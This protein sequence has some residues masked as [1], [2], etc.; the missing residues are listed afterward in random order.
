M[1]DWL[2]LMDWALML[3]N[4]RYSKRGSMPTKLAEFFAAGVRP[5][6]HGCNE[7]VSRKIREAGAGVVLEGI[8]ESDLR[9]GARKV[10][11]TS[12]QPEETL[13]ARELTRAHFSLEAG[14]EKYAALLHKLY[15]QEH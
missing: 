15:S 2:K 14:V 13:R 10:A 7:E 12:L 4:T 3:L 1:A 8:S 9:E 6:Q 5:I 11:L